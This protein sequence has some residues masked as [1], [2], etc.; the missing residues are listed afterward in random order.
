MNFKMPEL[1]DFIPDDVNTYE[2]NAQID[3]L[4]T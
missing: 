4:G 2:P 3:I 1:I